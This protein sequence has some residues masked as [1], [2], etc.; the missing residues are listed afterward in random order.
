MMLDVDSFQALVAEASAFAQR[1]Q[2]PAH[3]LEAG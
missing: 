3:A 2:H 1:S